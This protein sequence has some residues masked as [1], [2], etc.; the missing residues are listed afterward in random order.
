MFPKMLSMMYMALALATATLPVQARTSPANVTTIQ[1][2][3]QNFP[4]QIRSMSCKFTITTTISDAFLQSNNIPEGAVAPLQVEQGEWA[5]KDDKVINRSQ[6]IEGD[7]APAGHDTASVYLFD[8]S[9]SYNIRSENG[10]LASRST[11]A[12]RQHQTKA[13]GYS[14]PLPFGYQLN[15]QWLIDVLNGS[16]PTLERLGVDPTFGQLYAIHLSLR[17]EEKWIWFAPK[18]DYVA[19]KI[20]EDDPQKRLVYMGTHYKLINHFWLPLQGDVQL[21]TKQPNG[22]MV[23]QFEKKTVFSDIQVNNV[24]DETFEFQWPTGAALYDNDTQTKYWRDVSGKWVPRTDVGKTLAH[25]PNRL[26]AADVVPWVFLVC[27]A[28]LLMLGLLRWRRRASA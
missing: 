12:N 13:A 20:V 8:G 24:P 4:K 28:S 23:S 6:Y 22:Q 17:G 19:V 2:A 3:I 9:G 21:L 7:P 14:G 26:S 10:G 1:S 5:F 18:Y 11:Y 15:S 27:L 25:S 16:N